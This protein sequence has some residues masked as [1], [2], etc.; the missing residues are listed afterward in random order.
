MRCSSRWGLCSPR[1]NTA[2]ATTDL[3]LLGPTQVWWIFFP[4][5]A[6]SMTKIYLTCL[7]PL[8]PPSRPC[9]AFALC[10]PLR[11]VLGESYK[12]PIRMNEA[13]KDNLWTIQSVYY[14]HLHLADPLIL[15]RP[16]IGLVGLQQPHMEGGSAPHAGSGRPRLV[17]TL[18][19]QLSETPASDES[20]SKKVA[21]TCLHCKH[22]PCRRQGAT[23][24]LL[25]WQHSPGPAASVCSTCLG[26]WTRGRARWPSAPSPWATVLTGPLWS[27]T[28]LD[29][30]RTLPAFVACPWS[31]GWALAT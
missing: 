8:L 25:L 17:A 11:T 28:G 31:T 15:R 14:H 10:L 12:S 13:S 19:M 5:W 18:P 9:L 23:F 6:A 21:L 3:E 1:R 29:Y 20:P 16:V 27:G 2:E 4:V 22:L 24:W 7:V 26:Q 30:W